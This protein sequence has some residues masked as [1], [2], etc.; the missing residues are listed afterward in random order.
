MGSRE[1]SLGSVKH[2]ITERS[3]FWFSSIMDSRD[4]SHQ[5]IK[6]GSPI[7]FYDTM[8]NREIS[9]Q[10]LWYNR[11]QRDSLQVL[12]YNGQQRDLPL[13]LQYIGQQ[14]DILF[15]F[16]GTI[17]CREISIQVL[18]YVQYRDFSLGSVVQ[19]IAEKSLF[20]SVVKWIVESLQQSP[21][22]FCSIVD[23][24]EISYQGSVVK[25][26]VKRS[27]ISGQQKDLPLD[28][29][30][31]WIEER[32]PSRFCITMDSREISHQFLLY[33]RQQRDLRLL[34]SREISY[35]TLQYS[36]QQ[37]DPPLVLW[38]N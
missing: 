6:E 17:G 26:I 15:R 7:P 11:Q 35:Q 18:Y 36:E 8:D 22:R 23:S 1:I 28:S 12:W 3:P 19:W 2:W 14:R 37:R 25:W 13:G 30:V 38:Y 27:P 32:S 34:D 20:G 16:C 10:V 24:R 33:N 5:W 31:Q 29:V 21:V 9:H 4:L